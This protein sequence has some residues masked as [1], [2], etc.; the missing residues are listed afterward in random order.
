MTENSSVSWTSFTDD[1]PELA[2]S[3]AAR[4][5]ATKHHVLATLRRD[6]APRVSG[7]EVQFQGGELAVGM[8]HGSMKALDLLRDG[9]FALHAN[10]GDGSMSGGDAKVSGVAVEITDA[11]LLAPYVDDVDPPTPFH[12]FYLQPLEVVLTTLH[13]D[14]DRLVIETWRPHTGLTRVERL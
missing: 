11:A 1:S 5:T 6:G 9:R 13:P 2:A 4:F 7:S 14:G 8:M 10:P 12:L 3:V